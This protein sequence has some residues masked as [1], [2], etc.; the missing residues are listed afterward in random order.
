MNV[1]VFHGN[2]TARACILEHEFHY[3]DN[4]SGVRQFDKPPKVLYKFNVSACAVACMLKRIY[5][6]FTCF[7]RSLLSRLCAVSVSG[8]CHYL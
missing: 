2:D 6:I 1:V 4:S 8:A 3:A 5:R 7:P